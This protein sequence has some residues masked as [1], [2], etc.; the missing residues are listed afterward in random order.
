MNGSPKRA[1]HLLFVLTVIQ[2]QST[3]FCM[4]KHEPR[5]L[6]LKKMQNIPLELQSSI[7]A[8]CTYSV[9]LVHFLQI[10]NMTD[11][12]LCTL[13]GPLSLLVACNANDTLF[14]CCCKER[15]RQLNVDDGVE[16][17]LIQEKAI[18]VRFGFVCEWSAK[19]K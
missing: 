5:E 18:F 7:F 19:I 11:F 13:V 4:G 17:N 6:K 10:Q 16:T 2:H 1:M 8:L 3:L 12:V 14:W 9:E 15:K